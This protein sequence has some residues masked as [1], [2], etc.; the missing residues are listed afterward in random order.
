MMDTYPGLIKKKGKKNNNNNNDNDVKR[1]TS[2]FYL[3]VFIFLHFPR[4]AY[5]SFKTSS[6]F[7]MA[8]ITS[9]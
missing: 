1:K 7:L 8:L 9:S 6:I 5:V 2:H 3:L 4:S